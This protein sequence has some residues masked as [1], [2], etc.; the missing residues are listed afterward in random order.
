VDIASHQELV[1]SDEKPPMSILDTLPLHA[2]VEE[3]EEE[4]YP[5]FRLPF[6][7]GCCPE[8]VSTS[9][10]FFLQLLLAV[11]LDRRLA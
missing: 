3:E 4:E 5:A 8:T 1:F 6:S 2:H 10:I 7:I 9:P 11:A